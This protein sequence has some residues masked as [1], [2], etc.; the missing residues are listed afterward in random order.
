MTHHKVRRSGRITI[1][2]PILLIGSD[3]EGRVFSEETKTVILSL[4]GAGILSR[5]KLVSEQELV[6]RSLE[7]NREA[8]IRVVG[9]IG[10]Q[11][12]VHAYGVAFVHETLDFWQTAFPPPE[13]PQETVSSLS[14]NAQVALPQSS[15]SMEEHGDDSFLENESILAGNGSCN[16]TG[17][18][19]RVRRRYGTM[20]RH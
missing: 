18:L 2:V 1:A 13:S 10:S 14:R 15:W 19:G 16:S 9:E 11:G 20:P 8:D 6:L 5:H 12:D 3:C 17:R 7:S 4:H